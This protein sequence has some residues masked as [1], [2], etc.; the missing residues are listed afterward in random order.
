MTDVSAVE[1]A[2]NGLAEKI[3]WLESNGFSREDCGCTPI[4]TMVLDKKRDESISVHLVDVVWRAN[5]HSDGN[6]LAE[7][8]SALSP[9][10]ALAKLNVLS[11][12]LK[13]QYERSVKFF[14]KIAKR[15]KEDG[16]AG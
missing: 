12:E 10:D 16:H 4:W 15:L 7:E 3:R 11:M 13:E 5:Y 2:L 6:V 1:L 9:Q 14:G 8:R